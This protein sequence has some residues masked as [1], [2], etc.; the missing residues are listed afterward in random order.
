MTK[1]SAYA[2]QP[3]R[4]QPLLPALGPLPGGAHLRLP[5]PGEVII[6]RGQR[7][8]GQ[9]RGEY[10][11][12]GGAR[13]CLF[14]VTVGRHDPGLEER[15]DQREHALVRDPRAEAAHQGDM[16]DFVEACPDVG[17]QDPLVVPRT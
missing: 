13:V 17:L 3:P 14:P 7:D 6:Q 12:G 15:L 11:A 8:V 1:S 4:A 9:Q 5:L 16:P 2:D 10:P